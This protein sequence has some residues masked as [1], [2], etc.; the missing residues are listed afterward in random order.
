MIE[1]FSNELFFEK[2]TSNSNLTLKNWV[3]GIQPIFILSHALSTN[4][5]NICKHVNPYVDTERRYYEVTGKEDHIVNVN[6]S[7]IGESPG[8]LDQCKFDGYL[9]YDELCN[10]CK[11]KEFKEQCGEVCEKTTGP[12]FGPY[13]LKVG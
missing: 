4:V 8:K 2:I 9:S 13:F 5:V 1:L 11:K 7:C 10:P 3:Y 12:L 6:T